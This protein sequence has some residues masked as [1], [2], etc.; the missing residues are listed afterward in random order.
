MDDISTQNQNY[1]KNERE[2]Q[3]IVH[4]SNDFFCERFILR[5]IKKLRKVFFKFNNLKKWNREWRTKNGLQIAFP[6]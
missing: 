2:I 5:W 4:Y 3:N 1:W 6:H